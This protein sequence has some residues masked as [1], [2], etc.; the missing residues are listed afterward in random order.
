MY[1]IWFIHRVSFLCYILLKGP[2]IVSLPFIHKWYQVRHSCVADFSF[3]LLFYCLKYLLPRPGELFRAVFQCHSQRVCLMTVLQIGT[4]AFWEASLRWTALCIPLTILIFLNP[5]PLTF[6]LGI[7]WNF[8]FNIQNKSTFL[9]ML[10]LYDYYLCCQL[11]HICWFWFSYCNYSK[12]QK[13]SFKDS[14]L[15]DYQILNDK[16]RSICIS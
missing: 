4:I 14:S 13:K 8:F 11:S 2:T 6:I 9:N 1:N 16:G 5:E 3:V 12:V 10:N 15:Q 7:S